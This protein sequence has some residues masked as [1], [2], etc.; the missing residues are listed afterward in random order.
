MRKLDRE[1]QK[2]VNKIKRMKVGDLEINY[3]YENVDTVAYLEIYE[4]GKNRAIDIFMGDMLCVKI[5]SQEYPQFFIK[6][7]QFK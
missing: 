1:L 3:E 6:A 5:I 7:Q 2:V 4:Y